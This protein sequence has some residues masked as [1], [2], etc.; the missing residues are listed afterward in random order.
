MTVVHRRRRVIAA[1]RFHDREAVRAE[2]ADHAVAGRL[3]VA[4]Q[5][6]RVV[7]AGPESR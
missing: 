2:P 1:R 4:M 5:E 6:A 3:E 7:D